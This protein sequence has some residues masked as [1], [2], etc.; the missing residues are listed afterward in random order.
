MNSGH[1]I[2]YTGKGFI[3]VSGTSVR[4]SKFR[5]IVEG[6]PHAIV[7]TLRAFKLFIA[8]THGKYHRAT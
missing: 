3:S 1:S 4:K 8:H 7:R 2:S 6:N 5:H